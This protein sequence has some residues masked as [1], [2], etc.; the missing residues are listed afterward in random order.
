M[1]TRT[2]PKR[3]SVTIGGVS[4]LLREIS[5]ENLTSEC[6]SSAVVG[7]R[8]A[9]KRHRSGAR[10]NNLQRAA[11]PPGYELTVEV[12]I[13]RSTGDTVNPIAH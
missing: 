2:V 3:L 5:H 10:G 12:C 11:C 13:S 6:R 1:P 9:T 8:N 7:L 4:I